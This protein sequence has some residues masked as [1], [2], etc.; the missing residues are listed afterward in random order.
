MYGTVC[1]VVWEGGAVRSLPIPISFS[2][3]GKHCFPYMQDHG[4][5]TGDLRCIELSFFDFVCQLDYA[6]R[7]LRIPECL[8]PQHRVAMDIN[9]I[10]AYSGSSGSGGKLVKC[11]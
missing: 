1:T 9:I 2:L 7:Y 11:D 6:Q 10:G 3:R 4:P 5:W 8:K